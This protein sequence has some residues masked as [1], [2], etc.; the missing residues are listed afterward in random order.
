MA[1]NGRPR[2]QA[3]RLS[4]IYGHGATAIRALTGVNLTVQEGEFVAVLGPSGSGKTTLIHLL[5]GLD[6]PSEGRILVNGVDLG[7]LNDARRARLRRRQIGLIPRYPRLVSVLTLEENVALPLLL[8]GRPAREAQAAAAQALERIGLEGRGDDDPEH[9]A[10]GEA[11]RV[12]LARALAVGPAVI[13]A[14]EPTGDLNEDTAEAL[15]SLL[16]R[17]RDEWGQSLLLTTHDIRVAAYADRIV[18]LRDG[19]VL[20]TTVF[21]AEKYYPER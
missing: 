7:R 8:D 16:R 1:A 5:A 19:I 14:D 2:L 3:E 15:L 17:A 21:D 20:D 6:L 4:R 9:L 11:Q 18:H 12:A 10:P 13:L